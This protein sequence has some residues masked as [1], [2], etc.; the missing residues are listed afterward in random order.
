MRSLAVRLARHGLRRDQAPHRGSSVFLA[1]GYRLRGVRRSPREHRNSPRVRAPSAPSVMR[2]RRPLGWARGASAR[3][4]PTRGDYLGPPAEPAP[5]TAVPSGVRST[6]AMSRF[7][8]WVGRR[9]CTQRHRAPGPPP[10]SRCPPRARLVGSSPPIDGGVFVLATPVS[11]PDPSTPVAEP[12]L[13]RPIVY[14]RTSK[15]SPMSE[16]AT[17]AMA[18][19]KATRTAPR[20]IDEPPV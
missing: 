4:V 6:V 18:P 20:R 5:P 10:A 1:R 16:L 14:T 12:R 17:M 11:R 3:A 13:F 7:T 2:P 19:Q 8:A 15:R 9:C